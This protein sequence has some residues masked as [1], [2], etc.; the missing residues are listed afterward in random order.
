MVMEIPNYHK[1]KHPTQLTSVLHS[2]SIISQ[3][4]QILIL[5]LQQGNTEGVV[6]LLSNHQV[7]CVLIHLGIETG[8]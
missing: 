3:K 6:N 1:M 2:Q 4:L 7:M 5:F 8:N